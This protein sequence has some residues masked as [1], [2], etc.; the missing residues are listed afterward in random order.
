MIHR[1]RILLLALILVA[2]SSAGALAVPITFEITGTATG[3]LGGAPFTDAAF[4]LTGNAD[5]DDVS[6]VGFGFQVVNSSSSVTIAGL[7]TGVFSNETRTTANQNNDLGGFGEFFLLN[8]A[9]I[10]VGNVVFDTYQLDSDLGP[11]SGP[12]T[13]SPGTTFATSAGDF[14]F[15]SVLGE[16]TFTAVVPEPASLGLTA[17]GAVVWMTT[18]RRSGRTSL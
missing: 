18:R 11:V 16:A 1:S 5:T 6:F 7:G 8:A 4:T 12:A 14:I 9:V 2:T 17:L 13:I 10:F 15:S 3:S